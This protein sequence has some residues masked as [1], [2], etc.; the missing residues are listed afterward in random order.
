SFPPTSSTD[1]SWIA[2]ND[3]NARLLLIDAKSGAIKVADQADRMSSYDATPGTSCFSPDSKYLAFARIE[4][5]WY[6]SVNLYEIASGHK[7][8]VTVPR[9]NSYMP[10][11]HS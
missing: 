4:P 10:S 1:G 9:L 8:R 2:L 7:E 5:N 3:R 6:F 11:S